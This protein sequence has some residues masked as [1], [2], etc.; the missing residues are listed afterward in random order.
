M[1]LSKMILTKNIF[2]AKEKQT[3]K[4]IT[5]TLSLHEENGKEYLVLT[6]ADEGPGFDMSVLEGPDQGETYKF[7]GRGIK[8]TRRFVDSI[9][10]NKTG[11]EAT[12]IKQ[13][14]GGSHGSEDDRCFGNISTGPY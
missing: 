2:S 11:N 8:I 3:D 6:T 13:I 7:N 4:K 12:V 10:Y 9:F 1:N 5:V 14:T